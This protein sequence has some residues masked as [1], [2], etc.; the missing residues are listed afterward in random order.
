MSRLVGSWPLLATHNPEQ[1][2]LV[3]EVRDDGIGIEADKLAVIFEKFTQ[4][5]PS[6]T[7]RYEGAGLGLA[8]TRELCARMGASV[9][10]TSEPGSGAC[11]TV[12]LP[13]LISAPAASSSTSLM[14]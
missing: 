12:S 7:R 8:I 5:D 2:L 4:L 3:F 1:S 14:L 13:I 10:V 9:D 11:F 6:P